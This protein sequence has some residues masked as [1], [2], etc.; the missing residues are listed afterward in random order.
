MSEM[1]IGFEMRKIRVPLADI[2]PVRQIK[3]QIGRAHV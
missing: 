2:L 3:D 1:K